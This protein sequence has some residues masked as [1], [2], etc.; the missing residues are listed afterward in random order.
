M[1]HEIAINAI[2]KVVKRG[3]WNVRKLFACSNRHSVSIISIDYFKFSFKR[4]CSVVF[5][6]LDYADTKRNGFTLR[7][8]SDSSHDSNKFSNVCKRS[9]PS[10]CV[11]LKIGL[12]LVGLF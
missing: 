11:W 3:L 10:V 8:A 1:S 5:A 12:E 2:R 6:V 4:Y 7:F 9:F